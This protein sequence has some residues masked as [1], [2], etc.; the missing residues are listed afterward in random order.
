MPARSVSVLGAAGFTGAL[1]ARLLYR[2]PSFELQ[3]VTARSDFGKRLDELYPHHRVPLRLE[4]LDLD[5]HAEV[6][7]AVVAYPHGASATLVAALRERGV[8]VVDLSADF[9][10]R[11]PAIYE[12]WYRRIWSFVATRFI[13][14][15]KGGW[16]AQL[17]DTL[18]PNSGPFFGKGDIYHS[19]QACLIPSLPTTGSVTRG[20]VGVSRKRVS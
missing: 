13:D 9:R 7:A 16:R 6:D 5:K 12:D 18:Q 11:D 14:R 4:E 2:H 20:L 17:D 19:L 15:Q 10:L 3:A 8:R 1:T